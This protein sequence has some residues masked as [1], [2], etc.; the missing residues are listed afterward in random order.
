MRMSQSPARIY[1]H[2]RAYTAKIKRKSE[3]P[4]FFRQFFNFFAYI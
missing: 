4:M 1:A 2:F 3:N